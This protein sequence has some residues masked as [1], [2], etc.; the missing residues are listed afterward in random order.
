MVCPKC[1][2]QINDRT[3]FC[4]RCGADVKGAKAS[5]VPKVTEEET[6]KENSKSFDA[7]LEK[8]MTAYARAETVKAMAQGKKPNRMAIGLK[9][10]GKSYM[11]YE[12]KNYFRNVIWKIIVLAVAVAMVFIR[13]HLG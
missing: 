1:G 9:I 6:P 13:Q 2:A 10:F 12:K 8:E 3:R 4:V 7:R 5:G 11:R